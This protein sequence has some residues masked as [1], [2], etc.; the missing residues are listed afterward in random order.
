MAIFTT[1]HPKS[2]SQVIDQEGYAQPW[3]CAE[4]P[5]CVITFPGEGAHT[6]DMDTIDSLKMSP[7]WADVDTAAPHVFGHELE[8]FLTNHL[9]EHAAPTSPLVTTIINILNADR[10]RAAGH[11]PHFVFGHSIGEVAAG[12]AATLVS[13]ADALATAHLL[14][15]IGACCTGARR[16]RRWRT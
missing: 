10:W 13:L 12:Y 16:S 14:G 9:G 11:A 3:Q 1:P 8:P 6:F 2:C 5:R 7:I 15:Q 4:A